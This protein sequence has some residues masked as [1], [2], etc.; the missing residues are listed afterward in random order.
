MRDLCFSLVCIVSFEKKITK[1][2]VVFKKVNRLTNVKFI[3]FIIVIIFVYDSLLLLLI[4]LV[5]LHRLFIIGFIELLSSLLSM[6]KII[7]KNIISYICLVNVIQ[8]YFYWK[9]RTETRNEFP[10]RMFNIII[11]NFNKKKMISRTGPLKYDLTGTTSFQ[12]KNNH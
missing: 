5:L 2:H 1:K 7:R 11:S 3:I 6:Y 9:I 4:P 10:L 12:I 8:H